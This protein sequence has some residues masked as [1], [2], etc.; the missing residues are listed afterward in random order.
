[1]NSSAA[2]TIWE[3]GRFDTQAG[4]QRLLFGRVYED[5]AVELAAFRPSGRIFCIASAGCT[6]MKL[7][8]LGEVVAVDINPAQLE[9]VRRRLHGKPSEQGDADRL[10][11]L[12]RRF[13]R[14]AG[15]N[16]ARLQTFLELEEPPQQVE[17]WRR[18]LET[19]RFRAALSL[20]CSRPFLRTIYSPDLL[21]CLPR[22]FGAVVRA[23]LA[24]CFA[25]HPNRRNPY[26]RSLLLGEQPLKEAL[27]QGMQI[28]LV[29]ADAA[30]FLEQEPAA[31]FN[32]FAIS[33]ILDGA[34]ADYRRRLFAAVRHAA[35]PD[36]TVVL[37]SFGEPN[38]DSPTNRAVEDR[39]MLWGIVDVR[40]ASKLPVDE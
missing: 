5:A 17:F 11:A 36:A 12:A 31:S 39:A 24:R 15:W 9:Y 1:M 19:C 30:T 28:K 16:R 18:H 33:N 3:T 32:G 14:L 2:T 13:G 35:T 6:A 23:R 40:P 4:P 29:Q 22:N 37:R 7:A 25:T 21:K 27:A 8:E 34:S 38:T 20:L 10:L 26:A